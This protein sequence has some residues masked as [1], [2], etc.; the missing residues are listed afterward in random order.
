[1]ARLP[2]GEH[3]I[4]DIR[5]LE[6]YCLNAQHP[7]GRH[8][9]RVFRDALGIGRP[10]GRWLREMLLAAAQHTEATE[11]VSDSFG[12]R[13]R[14]DVPV[15]RQNRRIVLRSIWMTRSGED[16]PRFITCWVI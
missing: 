8:K 13:W 11:V 6:D 4:L 7:R 2:N 14:I 3:A 16:I 12:R 10:D 5:K 1:M 9:A 15:E